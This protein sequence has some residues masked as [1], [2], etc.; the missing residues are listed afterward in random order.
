MVIDL[1]KTDPECPWAFRCCTLNRRT[2]NDIYDTVMEF[3]VNC[4]AELNLAHVFV[5]GARGN[6]DLQKTNAV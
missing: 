6:I 3:N 4:K 2:K 5:I 1:I